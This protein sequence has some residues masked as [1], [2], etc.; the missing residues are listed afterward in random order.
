M[1]RTI[2][3]TDTYDC[4]YSNRVLYYSLALSLSHASACDS[5]VG[6]QLIVGGGALLTAGI[7][8]CSRV[9]VS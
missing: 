9:M 2:V 3:K 7:A 8:G 1:I 6:C 5:V 4:S